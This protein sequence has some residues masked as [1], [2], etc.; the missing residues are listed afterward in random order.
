MKLWSDNGNPKRRKIDWGLFIENE[1]TQRQMEELEREMVEQ[2]EGYV[3]STDE[4]L[5]FMEEKFEVSHFL[6]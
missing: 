4:F 3:F 2:N 5:S 1:E 6:I